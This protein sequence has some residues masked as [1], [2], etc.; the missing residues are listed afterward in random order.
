MKATYYSLA[1][2]LLF[3]T[4][5]K[6]TIEG[7]S[8]SKGNAD[9]SRY[10]AIGNSL[11]AGYADGS[12]YKS[13]QEN[14][15]PAMLAEKFKLV[16]GG[17][18]KQPLLPGNAGWPGPKR[19]LSVNPACDGTTSLG[20][21]LYS[22]TFDTAGS[23]TNIS[24]QGPFNNLG[25]PGIRCVDYTIA[26]Y[27]AIA[28]AIGGVGYAARMYPS[29]TTDRPIDVA[30][31]SNATFFT[32]WLG[33]N[34]VLGYALGGG[35]GNGTGGTLP[36][37]ISQV[38]A[39]EASYRAVADAMTANGA[40][41][42]L[43]NIPDV[44]TIPY[45]TTIPRNGL[46]LTRQGQVDSLN[47]AYA[48]LGISFS[49]G[50]NYFIIQDLAAPG[51]LRP[52]KEGEYL[53]LTTPQDSLKCRGWGSIKPIPKRYVLDA[54]EV[55]N[56]QTATTTFN[57]IIA[58]VAS[59]KKLPLVDANAYLKTLQSGIKFNGLSFG[60]TFVTGGAFSLD[61]VHLTPRG[62]ALVA[63]EV[64]RMINNFYGS[65]IPQ[66]DITRYNGVLFP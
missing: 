51:G 42:V 50:Q 4:A 32:M 30:A 37:D 60:P 44:T 20:P 14:S 45:F 7:D 29:P 6:P 57:G 17:D 1:A 36:S 2:G 34:D 62:Y 54:A 58:R 65:N 25:V 18:F 55:S 13:G 41:G 52:I 10:V 53:L 23:S 11:T 12:L 64:I 39:F 31:K 40:K 27:A 5:C 16:G 35:E 33:S 61:G 49:L 59:E 26:G 48:P 8:P 22:G 56:V 24:S 3:F 47:T 43:L 66:V 28:Q 46:N 19:V 9:F 21:S 15:Y 38:A 63:N